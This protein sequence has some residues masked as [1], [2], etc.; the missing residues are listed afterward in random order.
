MASL[1]LVLLL[2]QL[3][4]GAG[5]ALAD[6][7]APSGAPANVPAA[8]TSGADSPTDTSTSSLSQSTAA[9]V[10]A[11]PTS[12]VPAGRSTSSDATS[13]SPAGDVSTS[14]GGIVPSTSAASTGVSVVTGGDPT[15]PSVSDL[16]MPSTTDLRHTISSFLSGII[17]SAFP[18]SVSALA[19]QPALSDVAS[20]NTADHCRCTIAVAV[21]VGY[22]ASAIAIP[23]AGPAAVAPAPAAASVNVGSDVPSAETAGSTGNATSVSLSG[24]G[25]AAAIATS[26]SS[27]AAGSGTAI[28][29]EVSL[30]N[31]TVNKAFL[32]VATASFASSVL[33]ELGPAAQSLGM[34]PCPTLFCGPPP[35]VSVD[36]EAYVPDGTSCAPSSNS[37]EWC[38]LAI[39]VSLGGH[40][41]AVVASPIG[42]ASTSC[43]AGE[44]GRPT[45]VAIGLQGPASALS[46]M[47]SGGGVCP[48]DTG[49]GGTADPVKATSGNTGSALAIGVAELGPSGANATSGDSGQ[50]RAITDGSGTGL[51]AS[52]ATATTGDTGDA[53]GIAIGKTAASAL[54]HSGASGRAAA[55]CTHCSL[56]GGNTIA[57]ATTGRT[58]G[59]Y[60]LAVAGKESYSNAVS[61]DSGDAASW[62]VHGTAETFLTGQD[63]RAT[64]DSVVTTGDPQ[65]VYVAGRSG[66]TGNVVATATDLL[67]WVSVLTQS[68]NAGPVVST[69]EWNADGCTLIFATFTMQ[70]TA[71]ALPEP[72]AG[73][74]SQMAPN[75]VVS[76]APGAIVLQRGTETT[77]VSAPGAAGQS[78][79]GVSTTSG[80]RAV[81]S[82]AGQ[83]PGHGTDGYGG[84]RTR[85]VSDDVARPAVSPAAFGSLTSWW[86]LLTLCLLATFLV[87]LIFI[88]CRYGRPRNMNTG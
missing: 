44:V 38:T 28:G 80:S 82:A 17:G 54:V 65:T 9:P 57:E 33:N 88:A 37:P 72:V 43:T 45:A 71:N 74:G 67:T 75:P 1:A 84:A 48:G 4:G 30:G 2:F 81:G 23:G 40:A 69:A 24:N 60:S 63:S 22:T 41:H 8:A 59:S 19:G 52:S 29:H 26:G 53:V 5:A 61:G 3:F 64:P 27:S 46:R 76:P 7:S 68:G 70:C 83:A 10:S 11:V 20:D 25:P 51:L 78:R 85:L 50:V 16:P 56:A 55:L 13:G 21:S 14:T 36:V 18:G 32:G 35:A 42:A 79:E 39:A 6:P 58:G 66:D 73:S 87:A 62:A 49:A 15:I 31:V 34:L 77:P 86:G 12:E 47:G